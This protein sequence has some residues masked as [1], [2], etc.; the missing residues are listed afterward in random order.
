[1]EINSNSED[2]E[3]D[4]Y[5]KILNYFQDNKISRE[6]KEIWKN[7]SIIELMNLLERTQNRTFVTN[8]LILILSLFEDIPPD[9]YNNR[10]VNIARISEKDKKFLIKELK[11]EFLPN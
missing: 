2:F 7:R 1:M 6:K 11:E 5:L 10:G 3:L 4:Y 8:A 9:T